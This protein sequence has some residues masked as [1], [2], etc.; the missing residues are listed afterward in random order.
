M[1]WEFRISRDKLLY[2]EW[3]N[4]VL[5]YSIGNYIQCPV[6]NHNEKEHKKE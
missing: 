2:I 1:E 6:I 5:L 3:M 4:E